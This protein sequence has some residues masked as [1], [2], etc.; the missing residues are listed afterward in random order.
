MKTDQFCTYSVLDTIKKGLQSLETLVI[1]S[2]G[3]WTRT[4]D[5]RVMSSKLCYS[6]T[7]T[8]GFPDVIFENRVPKR[9]QFCVHFC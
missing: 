2:S 7:Q 1:P 3:N 8:L 5:L 9:V 4:S 6:L